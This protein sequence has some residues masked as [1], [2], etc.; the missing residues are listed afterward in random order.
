MALTLKGKSSHFFLIPALSQNY[1]PETGEGSLKTGAQ[2]PPLK[3]LPLLD[4]F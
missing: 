4:G 2:L 1:N 3:R